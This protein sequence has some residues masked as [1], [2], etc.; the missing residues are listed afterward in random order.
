MIRH[1]CYYRNEEI[2]NRLG[3]ELVQIIVGPEL[4]EFFAHK[5]LI[6]STCDFFDK[7]FNGRFKEGI[8][9]KML[10]P[11][12]DPEV[13][14]IFVNW[15]YSEHLRGGSKEPMLIINI[16][17][18][19]QKCQAITLKNC[20]MNALQDAL[21]DEIIKYNV[22]DEF[23]VF[24]VA[25]LAWE[26]PFGDPEDVANLE[27][28]FNDVNGS[29]EDVLE[30]TQD[31]GGKPV[32]DPRVR[33]GRCDNCAFYEHNYNDEL[34]CINTRVSTLPTDRT[35]ENAL[36]INEQSSGIVAGT[37]PLGTSRFY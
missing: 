14:E 35:L 6:R 25:M 23:R 36:Q 16:W 29:F 32:A 9:N 10:L 27:S 37:R 15:M 26:I 34:E 3:N 13:F 30:F 31:L 24:A 8:E 19:A 12:D 11:E 2:H 21:G 1:N 28:I 18:F 20:A 4:K 5:T 33:G 22:G 17:I 7:A